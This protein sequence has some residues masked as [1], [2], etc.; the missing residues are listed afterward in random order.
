L[1]F[2]ELDDRVNRF[3]AMIA[4]R[5]SGPGAVVA[6]SSPLSVDFIV[7]YY[8]TLRAGRIVAVLNPLISEHALLHNLGRVRPELCY[9][10]GATARSL[11]QVASQLRLPVTVIQHGDPV[12]GSMTGDV[13]PPAQA[14]DVACYLFT[15]G[16]TGSP[17]TVRLSHQNL[18]AN[19]AQVAQAHRLGPDSVSL[20]YLPS[21]H[22]MHLSSALHAGSTQV[23]HLGGDPMTAVARAHEVQA[24]HFYTI[25]M[26]LNLLAR[27][28]RIADLT[29]PSLRVIASG[30]S[31]LA[32]SVARRLSAH[33]GVPVIQGYGLAETSP[34]I[35]SDG[36]DAPVP[37]SV[38]R[39]VAHTECRVVEAGSGQSVPTGRPGEVQVRGPQVMLGYL[40][41]PEAGSPIDTDGWLSTGD[42]GR[43]DEDGVLFLID[44]LKDTFKCD[45]WLVS[46]S[47]LQAQLS[48]QPGVFEC[49]VFGVPD[50]TH[51]HV[52]AAML[53]L[54]EGFTAAD[55]RAALA[56]VAAARPY[57]E[58]IS[59]AV[60]VPALP[61]AANQKLD[62]R[63]LR[64]QLLGGVGE[65]VKL[66]TE[67]ASP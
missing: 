10:D 8:G 30:G 12:E 40:D 54:E 2:G 19:A 47:D 46:P 28:P 50:D 61:R 13:T 41:G 57:Y 63:Q 24:S 9:L 3:A 34:L 6:V 45:N 7:G 33:F 55:A 62:R 37:G 60:V 48:T 4:E 58:R 29:V 18:S 17:K 21:F 35:F 27:H 23:L 49:A 32:P 26:R 16:T 39:V 44:R 59:R 42:I 43:L 11:D 65:P 36:L 53:V 5:T 31:A 51:G 14:G 20:N 64:D 22:P 56:A 66:S 52:A 1:A 15:S 38:G 25:P 67:G